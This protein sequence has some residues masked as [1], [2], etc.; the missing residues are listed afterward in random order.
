MEQHM[1]DWFTWAADYPVKN[2]YEET[3]R[4]EKREEGL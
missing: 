2:Q 4:S 3:M 1:R